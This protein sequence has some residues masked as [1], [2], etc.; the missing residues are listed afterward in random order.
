M[1]PISVAVLQ[2]KYAI[3]PELLRITFQED[4]K[5]WRGAPISI[6]SSILNRVIR[7]RVLLDTNL[8]G[9]VYDLISLE[10][11]QATIIDDLSVIYTIPVT[12]TQNRLILSVLSIGYLIECE[13][14]PAH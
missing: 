2:I 4:L 9:G 6:D 13:L 7:P 12:R 3:P 14:V 10:G 11:L 8:V 1:N 5:V